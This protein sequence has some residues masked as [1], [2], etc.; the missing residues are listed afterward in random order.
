MSK[1]LWT[2]DD[3]VRVVEEW[4]LQGAVHLIMCEPA[5]GMV[6]EVQKRKQGLRPSYGSLAGRMLKPCN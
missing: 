2:M 3:V 5:P 4:D 6:A 1:T